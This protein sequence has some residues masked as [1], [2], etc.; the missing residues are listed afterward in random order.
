MEY[1]P[2]G[3][4]DLKLSVYCLGTMTWGARNTEAEAHAQ[5]D[6]AVE[7]G[8]NFIDNAEM[9]PTP[10]RQETWGR[11]EE[12][13][14]TWL[15]ARGRRERVIVATKVVGPAPAYSYV[16]GALPRLDRANI[17]RALDD[18]LRRLGTEYVDLYQ[19][20]WPDRRIARDGSSGA[21]VPPSEDVVP[22]EDTLAVL[23]EA[24]RAGKVRHLGVSNETPWGLMTF[25][26]LAESR[27]WP[28]M[29]SIQNR[30]NLLER[31][32]E[33]ALAEVA[34]RERC[35]LLAFSPL[36]GGALSGKYLGG[37]APAGSRFGTGGPPNRY[38]APR[39]A[40]AIAA[41]GALAREH[42]LDQSAMALAFV[43][44]RPFLTSAIIAAT[45]L[46]QLE[47]NLAS[48]ELVP[49]PEVLAGIEAI[50]QADGRPCG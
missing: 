41:Y 39:A 16:R 47:A 37:A 46:D 14:G 36:C 48:A 50:H 30:Y 8:I 22:L 7:A 34:I 17:T 1:R 15:K 44:T 12:I 20:H 26:A 6:R 29:V 38:A 25:L 10:V 42:G 19:L 3:T 43:R 31:D 11:T 9:Y 5:L 33:P 23:D 4:T 18:S 2:L 45:G 32:F 49:A 13:L 27:G 40:A 35:G 21:M 24:V 28:R